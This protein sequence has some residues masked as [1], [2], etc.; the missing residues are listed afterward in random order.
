VSHDRQ[1]TIYRSLTALYPRTFRD[2]YRED[3]T[4]LFSHQLTDEPPLRVWARTI[5]DLAVTVPTHHLEAR[6]HRPPTPALVGI[7]SVLAATATAL[8]VVL[9]TGAPSLSIVFLAVA[10]VSGAVGIWAWRAQQPVH[11]VASLDTLWWKLL[12]AGVSLVAATFAGM[13]IRWPIDLGESSY[14]LVV[15][16]MMTGFM[17][18]AVGLTLGM[19]A[20][21]RHRRHGQTAH[22]TA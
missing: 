8:A 16:S 14:W 10:L 2:D 17:L 22:G 13:A 11:D 6:M 1:L 9:G 3:L 4:V 20:L 21:I 5:R 7:C 18:G 19:A 15:I 12:V